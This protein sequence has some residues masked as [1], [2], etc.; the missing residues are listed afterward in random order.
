MTV[1]AF[2]QSNFH[3][4]V[5]LALVLGTEHKLRKRIQSDISIA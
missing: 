1:Y 4:S 5:N 2:S 3:I